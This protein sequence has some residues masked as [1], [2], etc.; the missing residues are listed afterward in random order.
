MD[1]NS[2]LKF[3]HTSQV[4]LDVQPA[5]WTKPQTPNGGAQHDQS[6]RKGASAE[7]GSGESKAGANEVQEKDAV[8]VGHMVISKLRN[9][10]KEIIGNLESQNKEIIGKLR[11]QNKEIDNLKAEIERM[12]ERINPA[13]IDDDSLWPYDMIEN[14]QKRPST[15]NERYMYI[16]GERDGR[17]G[18]GVLS[19]GRPSLDSRPGMVRVDL[20]L[21]ILV[22]GALSTTCYL[23]WLCV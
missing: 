10:N 4:A 16:Q 2:T 1:H 7:H 14:G 13:E 6:Q 11:S 19:P 21:R 5:D 17:E 8:A 15:Q 18:V 22:L 23:I 9:K 12:R 3:I 20:C